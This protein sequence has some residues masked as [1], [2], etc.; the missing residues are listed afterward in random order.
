VSE[1]TCHEWRGT[2]TQPNYKDGQPRHLHLTAHSQSGPADV[3]RKTP[4]V[5][6]APRCSPGHVGPDHRAPVTLHRTWRHLATSA[7]L[8]PSAHCHTYE[9]LSVTPNDTGASESP[10]DRAPG[11]EPASP[12]Y[13]IPRRRPPIASESEPGCCYGWGRLA[14]PIRIVAETSQWPFPSP[15]EGLEPIHPSGSNGPAPHPRRRDGSAWLMPIAR[16]TPRSRNRR[17]LRTICGAVKRPPDTMA[18]R[19]PRRGGRSLRDSGRGT[20]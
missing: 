15:T 4:R 9:P 19:L 17:R 16:P 8:P 3:S 20:G 6:Q 7:V 12:Q 2:F 13:R 1:R 18:G 5:P 10:T 11:G 14:C